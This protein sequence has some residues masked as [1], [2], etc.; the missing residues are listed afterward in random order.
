MIGE[1]SS[2]TTK[3]IGELVKDPAST[4][5]H[6]WTIITDHV[7]VTAIFIILLIISVGLL[8]SL[9]IVLICRWC[10]RK[11]TRLTPSSG[12]IVCTLT[13]FLICCAVCAVGVFVY[14]ACLKSVKDGIG[15]VGATLNT[16]SGRKFPFLVENIST[17]FKYSGKYLENKK[18]HQKISDFPG[19]TAETGARPPIF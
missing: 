8:L 10:C 15:G 18:K 13:T 11:A 1:I 6:L 2:G 14:F 9:F 12:Q 3:T 16:T 17:L 7:A 4:P 19:F 5:T